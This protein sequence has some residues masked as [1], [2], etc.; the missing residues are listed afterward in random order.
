MLEANGEENWIFDVLSKKALVTRIFTPMVGSVVMNVDGS[1]ARGNRRG[2]NKENTA[3]AKRARNANGKAK[4]K[5]C[6]HPL[7]Y[8]PEEKNAKETVIQCDY[9]VRNKTW[10]DDLLKVTDHVVNNV[11]DLCDPSMKSWL[12]SYLIR[13]GLLFAFTGSI[14]LET[15][16]GSGSGAKQC[17]QWSK[18]RPALID[19]GL[20]VLVKDTITGW[21]WFP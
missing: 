20:L 11:A 18:V 19:H 16:K 12:K 1:S 15:S 5:A 17:K 10:V 13:Q 8:L 14:V 9:G 7:P 6:A 21:V 2:A 4:A 3:P